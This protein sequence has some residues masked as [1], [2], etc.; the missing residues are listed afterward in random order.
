MMIKNE[1][2][3]LNTDILLCVWDIYELDFAPIEE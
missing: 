3:F 2:N 1:N